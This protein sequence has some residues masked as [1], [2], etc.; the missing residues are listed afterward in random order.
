[1]INNVA[2][3][4]FFYY[5]TFTAPDADGFRVDVEQSHGDPASMPNFTVQ[6]E[7]NIR[8]FN[9]DCTD[10]TVSYSIGFQNGQAWVE[11]NGPVFPA[12]GDI[13]ILSVKYETS[14]VVGQPIPNPSTVHYDFKTYIDGGTLVDLDL[15]GVDMKKK[16][17]K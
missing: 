15:D 7:S 4:V 9:G 10:P 5:T 16:G 14:S 6:N 8:L 11:F 2:P 17:N 12:Q 13:F 1:V 3:G